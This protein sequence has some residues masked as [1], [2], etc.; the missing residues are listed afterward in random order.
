L[1]N[2]NERTEA[3]TQG[4]TDS[5]VREAVLPFLRRKYGEADG[6]RLAR[7]IGKSPP[8]KKWRSGTSCRER[9]RALNAKLDRLPKKTK[10]WLRLSWR[11]RLGLD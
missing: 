3:F 11:R 1:D 8:T 2:Y 6:M 4:L 9:R 7:C 5:W 10:K